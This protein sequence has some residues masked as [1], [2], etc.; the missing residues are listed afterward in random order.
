M[1]PTS[2]HETPFSIEVEFQSITPTFQSG[3]PRPKGMGR[4]KQVYTTVSSRAGVSTPCA[5]GQAGVPGTGWTLSRARGRG[6]H[7]MAGM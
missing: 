5:E 3:K 6:T 7:A 1:C 4:V 2:R